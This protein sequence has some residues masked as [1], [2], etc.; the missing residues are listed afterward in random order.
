[1]LIPFAKGGMALLDAGIW[2]EAEALYRWFILL[3]DH[4]IV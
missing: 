4:F 2:D 3:Y 1:M